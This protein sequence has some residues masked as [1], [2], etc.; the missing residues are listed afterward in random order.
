MQIL[1]A[2]IHYFLHF[3]LPV[4]VSYRFFR[5][6]WKKATLIMWLT[7]LVDLDHLLAR[8]VFDSCR[9]SIHFHPL[10]SWPAIALYVLFFLIPKWRIPATGLLLHMATDQLDCWMNLLRCN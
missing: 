6:R 4:I 3:G 1:Q 5:P 10:H 9:C 8:P 7:M 2:I